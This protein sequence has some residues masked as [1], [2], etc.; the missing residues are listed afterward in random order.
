MVKKII[1]LCVMAVLSLSCEKQFQ[2][3]GNQ[4]IPNAIITDPNHV[5]FDDAIDNMDNILGGVSAGTKSV[6]LAKAISH[7][8]T[9]KVE[10]LGIN[11]VETKAETPFSNLI[12]IA[13]FNGGGYA[14]LGADKRIDPVIAVV[15]NG[16]A[17]VED[18][19]SLND[20]TIFSALT[21]DDLYCEEDEDYYIGN[22]GNFSPL[23]FIKNYL[24]GKVENPSEEDTGEYTYYSK[25][26]GSYPLAFMNTRWDQDFPF[27]KIFP[28]SSSGENWLAG[29]GTIALAQVL[30]KTKRPSLESDFGIPNVTWEDIDIPYYYCD[31][32]GE[33]LQEQYLHRYPR[34]YA[35]EGAVAI[36]C[37]TIADKIKVKY[38]FLGSGGTFVTPNRIKKYMRKIGYGNAKRHLGYSESVVYDMLKEDKPVIMAALQSNF[39]GH[40]W[41]VDAWVVAGRKN[42]N[43]GEEDTVALMHCN[44][45]WRGDCDG[46]YL[47]GVFDTDNPW[48][49]VEGYG[50][51]PQFKASWWFRII[52][53]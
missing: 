13:N 33:D 20:S 24:K 40:F 19:V 15:E 12:Y 31:G 7:V 26:D 18:F 28:K 46:Y 14:F 49:P 16:S 43:T 6:L 41:V 3:D 8:D 53:F 32:E 52:T 10:D 37:R 11:A 30:T 23:S 47:P 5:S 21:L 45:G 39:E 29:C 36:L 35:R 34:Y 2:I 51:S 38:N 44:W 42:V 1:L 25:L 9:L 50:V 22:T 48:D 17:T 4:A 27:N